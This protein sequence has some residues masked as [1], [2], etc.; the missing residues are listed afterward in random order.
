[1]PPTYDVWLERLKKRYDGTMPEEELRKRMRTALMEI[2][3]AT[4]ADY[5]YIVINDDLEKTVDLVNRIAHDEAVEPHY[6][7]AMV[8]AE[9][10]LGRI[11]EELAELV[12][13]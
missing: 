4:S 8:I 2:E 9:D 11:R 7:K 1:M 3:N 5:F 10:F 13:E 6:R 12:E